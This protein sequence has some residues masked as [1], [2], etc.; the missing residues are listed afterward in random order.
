M[1]TSTITGKLDK[2]QISEAQA[3]CVELPIIEDR[4]RRAGLPATAAA[5]NMAV[6]KIGFELADK[7]PD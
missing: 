4:L 1:K 7:L 5:L 6:K 3:L 2:K